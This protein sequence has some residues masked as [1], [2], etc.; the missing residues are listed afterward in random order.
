MSHI[1]LLGAGFSHNWG[2]PLAKS[3]T[4]SLLRDLHDDPVF[5]RALRDRPFEDALGDFF[6]ASSGSDEDGLRHR[7]LQDAVTALFARIN[8]TLAGKSFEF[9][10]DMEFSV[11]QFLQ[12]FDAIFTLNQDLLLET[13]Y[14][15]RLV[16]TRWSGAIVP[17]M[18][19]SYE[20]GHPG[21]EDVTAMTW[22]PMENRQIPERM[23]PYFKLHGSSNWKLD[24]GDTI[25]IMGSAKAGI[26]PR[27]PV[28]QW[29]H[30]EFRSRLS[31][32]STKLMVI[33]YSFMDDHINEVIHDA[34][35]RHGL[36]TYIVDPQG[37][38]LLKEPKARDAM[39]KWRRDLE[40]IK[41]IG[42]CLTPP[43]SLF[44][45]DSFALGELL[46]FFA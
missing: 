32:P 20:A 22:R 40:D 19:A 31:R 44:G 10:N 5:E 4:G 26:I 6:K 42:E 1:L 23:Q 12:R 34:W 38:D 3:V 9:S 15:P 35:R 25:M 36:Q 17:G 24:T 46:R 30:D 33:G 2:A 7:R 28:L 39:I 29:Y 14:L 37:K 13:A 16:S 27:Y 43:R 18:K 45:G 21:L 41:L 11:A 8:V